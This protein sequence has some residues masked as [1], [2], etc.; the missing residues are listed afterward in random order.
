MESK[1]LTQETMK[2]LR[3]IDTT[4]DLRNYPDDLKYM[5]DTNWKNEFK[6]PPRSRRSKE[7][8]VLHTAAGLGAEI[9]LINSGAFKQSAPITEGAKGLTYVDRMTDATCEGLKVQIKSMSSKYDQWLISEGQATSLSQSQHHNALYIVVS[10]SAISNL[11]YH[12]TPRFIFESQAIHTCLKTVN[13]PYSK[14]AFDHERA[15]RK[16]ICLDLRSAA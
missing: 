15:I 16:G 3:E 13:M 1:M 9:A 7:M 8:V 11:K 14:F 10:Y 12:Y 6:K 4:V 5:V 2:L